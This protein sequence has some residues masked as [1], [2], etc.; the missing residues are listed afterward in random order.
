MPALILAAAASETEEDRG[1]GDAGGLRSTPVPFI[2]GERE[3]GNELRSGAMVEGIRDK[4]SNVNY[5]RGS[6]I[7]SGFLQRISM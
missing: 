6:L 3:G 1:D 2:T 5:R 7:R 4:S